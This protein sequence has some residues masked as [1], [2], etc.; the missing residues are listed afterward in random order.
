MVGDMFD[1]LTMA[2]IATFS[3]V[4][5]RGFQQKNVHGNHYFLAGITSFVQAAVDIAVITFIAHHGWDVFPYTAT[6]AVTGILA[7]M[8]IH[9]R[10]TRGLRKQGV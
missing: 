9:G 8:Y 7:A 3:M 1:S 10:L 2:G 5:L 4:F 6:G